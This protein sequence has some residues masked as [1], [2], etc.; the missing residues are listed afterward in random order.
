MKFKVE[1]TRT[2]IG[3][4]TIEVEAEN[5]KEANE[6]ALDEAGDHEYSEKTAEYEVSNS[7]NKLERLISASEIA[8][9]QLRDLY[10][11][12]LE[13]ELRVDLDSAI[14]ELEEAITEAKK[15]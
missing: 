12:G 13:E 3:F 7:I 10:P 14:S 2:G 8:L 4:H 5:Q 1:V 15:R 9:Y 6:K 11:D